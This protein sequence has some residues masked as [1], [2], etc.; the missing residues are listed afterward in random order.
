MS[1]RDRPAAARGR[2][3]MVEVFISYGRKNRDL[4][5]PIATRLEE[6]GVEKWIDSGIPT[7]ER[8]RK[9]IR[10]KRKDAKAVLVCWSP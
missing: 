5:E 10:G 2:R 7:G 3:P 8:Y 9:E 1:P 4:V 6:L